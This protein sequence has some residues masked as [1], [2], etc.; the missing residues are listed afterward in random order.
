MN[1]PDGVF[2]VATLIMALQPASRRAPIPHLSIQDARL[3]TAPSAISRL[4]CFKADFA[5]I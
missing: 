5:G 4:R 1:L 3:D 2:A